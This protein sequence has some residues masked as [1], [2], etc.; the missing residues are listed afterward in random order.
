MYGYVYKIT[1]LITNKIYI[2]KHKYPIPKLDENYITSGTYIRNSI[3]FYGEENFLREIVDTAETLE[4]LNTKEKFWIENL[5]CRYPN[6]YNLTEGGDGNVNLVPELRYKLA[7]WAGKKQPEEMKSKRAKANT[8]KKR[9][10]DTKEK[11]RLANKGQIQT[12]NTIQRSIEAHKN[13][14]WW[15]NGEEEHMFQGDPP[16]GYVKGRLKN[17]FPN[18]KGIPKSEEALKKLSEKKKGSAWYNNGT[19]S[20]MFVITEGFVVPEGFV[21][22]RL[23]KRKD[24]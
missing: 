14:S 6:G 12:E 16:E 22:G 15:N 8:G 20:K 19:I 17:P 5:N 1:N 13:S 21:K 10:E 2:G 24:K 4:E 7:Y 18:Q 3:D 23:Y 11:L 9:T